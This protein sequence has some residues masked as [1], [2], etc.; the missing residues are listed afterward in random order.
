MMKWQ[1]AI[2]ISNNPEDNNIYRGRVLY[3]HFVYDK[4]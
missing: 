4:I 3:F 2:V 1:H